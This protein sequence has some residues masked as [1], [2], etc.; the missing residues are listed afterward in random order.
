MTF[1]G[2]DS[3]LYDGWMIA[4]CWK[5]VGSGCDGIDGRP[6]EE[7]L[8]KVSAVDNVIQGTVTL[9]WDVTSLGR[10]GPRRICNA[11]GSPIAL[12]G[13]RSKYDRTSL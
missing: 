3:I 2:T 10:E 1:Q 11:S 13:Y 9:S 7:I 6:V 5:E 12:V 4:V 8:Y